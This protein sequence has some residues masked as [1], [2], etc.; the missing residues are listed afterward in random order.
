M[1]TRPGI[2][3]GICFS[4]GTPGSPV[5]C[6]KCSTPKNIA[7]IAINIRPTVISVLLPCRRHPSIAFPAR[8]QPAPPNDISRKT[9][10][11]I[12]LLCGLASAPRRW[13]IATNR[14]IM[15]PNS[16]PD[17]RTPI[18]VAML[19]DAA[20]SAQPTKYTQNKRHGMYRGTRFMSSRG[21]KRCSAPKTASGMAKHKLL[22]AT[23][24]SRPRAEAISLFAANTSI[25][26]ASVTH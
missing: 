21:P 8:I 16:R 1:S 14:N 24:L 18:L 9:I 3:G 17:Q 10:V 23:I 11:Q 19:K 22:K 7:A 5:G 26:D 15:I 13:I 20:I 12:I 6:R 25:K 2:H 4:S